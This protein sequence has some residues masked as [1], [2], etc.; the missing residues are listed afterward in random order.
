ML[1]G[2]RN[3]DRTRDRLLQA[4]FREIYR[5]GFQ[6]ANLDTV[7][8]RAGVTKGAL[9]HH[10]PSKHELGYAVLEEVLGELIEE[11]WIRPM[12][13]AVDPINALLSALR[14]VAS[15]DCEWGCPLNNL[16]QEMSAVDEGFHRRIA[17]LY[18]RWEGAVAGALERGQQ[19]DYIR[20]DLD[21]AAAATFIVAS[22]E[23]A[24]GLAK[25]RRSREPLEACSSG[26][27]R[28]LETLRPTTDRRPAGRHGK[29]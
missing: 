26:L 9:Y 4:G 21:V 1:R 22:I 12:S 19:H 10:F 14:D 8:D 2:R 20:K 25:N 15:G 27:M 24:F 7:V 5:H 29:G 13:G 18:R 28:Y 23:G 16:A 17:N 11:R 3:P 6:P